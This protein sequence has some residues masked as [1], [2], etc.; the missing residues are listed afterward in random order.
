ML[1][2]CSEE[3][4]DMTNAAQISVERQD[5]IDTLDKHREFL[6]FTVRDLDEAQARER[7]TVSELCLA[8]VIKHVAEMEENWADFIANGP[9][10]MNERMKALMRGGWDPALDDRFSVPS[11]A[12]LSYLLERYQEAAMRTNDLLAT[13]SS[14]DDSQPLPDAPWFTDDRW[15]NRRVALHIIAETA[16]HAGH[17]DIIR[18]A[19]DGS[20]SMG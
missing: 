17:A 16:Q 11:D 6:R 8:S 13:V 5:L 2:P 3:R 18:E 15:T 12:R 9:E 20:K 14:L 1:S 7:S 4:I 10:A 19:I